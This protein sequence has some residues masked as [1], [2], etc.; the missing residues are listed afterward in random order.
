MEGIKAYV[1]KQAYKLTYICTLYSRIYLS[2]CLL[3]KT[4][5]NSRGMSVPHKK[6]IM[7]PLR[8]QQVKAIYRFVTMVD[9]ILI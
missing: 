1:N 2:F 6:H 7:S 5:L 3:F 8:S 9:G 4:Q